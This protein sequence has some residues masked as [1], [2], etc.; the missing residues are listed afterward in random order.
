M[1]HLGHERVLS[2]LA[3]FLPDLVRFV[4]GIIWVT[5]FR[6]SETSGFEKHYRHKPL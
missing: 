5:L 4:P 1:P 6:V 3:G 2:F